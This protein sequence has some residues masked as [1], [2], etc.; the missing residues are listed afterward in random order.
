M[1][2]GRLMRCRTADPGT[3]VGAGGGTGVESPLKG[4][5]SAETAMKLLHD[6]TEAVQKDGL[7]KEKFIE[8]MGEV[9]ES[10]KALRLDAQSKMRFDLGATKEMAR[11]D[12]RKMFL[13]H[14]SNE[15]LKGLQELSDDVHIVDGILGNTK[16]VDNYGGM[17]SLEIFQQWD[18]AYTD[19][20]KAMDTAESGGG[21]EWVPGASLSAE[22]QYA[23]ELEARIFTLFPTFEMPQSPFKWPLRT[24]VG[25]AYRA[26][27]NTNLDSLTKV[28]KSSLGTDDVTFDS[29]D[30]MARVGYSGQLNERAIVAMLSQIKIALVVA[31]AN[32]KDEG[33]IDGQITAVI[34]TG[35]S[36]AGTPADGRNL[37]DGIRYYCSAGVNN[38]MV[39]LGSAWNVEGLNSVRKKLGKAGLRPGELAWIPGISTYYNLLTI[40]D[41]QNNNVVLPVEAYGSAAT[42]LTGELGKLFGTPIVPTDYI[43][44]DLNASGIYDGVT[45]TKTVL[46]IVHTKS[47]KFGTFGPFSVR[48]SDEIHME[49][50]M[51]VV[52]THEGG[53]FQAMFPAATQVAAAIGYNV[54]P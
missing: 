34:D 37:W 28:T 32:T 30:I 43:R 49:S 33:V 20:M 10:I 48:S 38:K 44:E 40:K 27:E 52:V 36:P 47:W 2:F 21:A 3:A 23:V 25:T 5:P 53:D 35:D 17:K 4:A 45:E 1:K 11:G 16:R 54:A 7:E 41:N 31:H 6:L 42:I 22:M 29:E 26:V 9:Q 46:P 19:F 18:G 13:T 15:R 14:T 39:D 12:V 24:G 50:Y 8:V 51:S